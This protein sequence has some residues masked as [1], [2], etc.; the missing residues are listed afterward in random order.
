MAEKKGKARKDPAAKAAPTAF[1]PRDRS[2]ERGARG[3]V[4]I[5]PHGGG[6]PIGKPAHTRT[7]AEKWGRMFDDMT[8]L[9]DRCEEA[10]SLSRGTYLPCAAPA[11]ALVWHEKDRRVYQMCMPCA[12]HNVRNR[13]GVLVRGD[14]NAQPARQK[15]S[16]VKTGPALVIS[17]VTILEIKALRRDRDGLEEKLAALRREL[18]PR[19]DTVIAALE[20]GVPLGPGCPPCAVDVEERIVLG[21]KEIALELAKAAGK[22]PEVFE[23]EE[24]GKV[25]PRKYRRLIINGEKG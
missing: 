14:L 15:A 23:A 2:V 20:G 16:P 11:M 7:D 17:T 12:G 1:N 4:S 18:K 8:L 3:D 24:R 22:N 25:E 5:Y 10:S 9:L 13:G 6:M 19:E 21:W